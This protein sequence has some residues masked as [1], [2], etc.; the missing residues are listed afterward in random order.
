MHPPA[1]CYTQ[2]YSLAVFTLHQLEGKRKGI[3]LYMNCLGD[4]LQLLWR[5][6]LLLILGLGFYR[7]MAE[8]TIL[9]KAKEFDWWK[10]R[11]QSKRNPARGGAWTWNLLLKPD[12]CLGLKHHTANSTIDCS[13]ALHRCKE[14]LFGPDE[15]WS[16]SIILASTLIWKY[17]GWPG[18][19]K[20]WDNYRVFKKSE[21]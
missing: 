19:L 16:L 13:V 17:T 11:E 4:F 1:F 20:H 14:L 3:F 10:T 5:I 12:F 7:H 15:V 18:L 21:M 6:C 8:N 9:Q 2:I